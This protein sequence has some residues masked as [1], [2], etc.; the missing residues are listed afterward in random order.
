MNN[1]HLHC[2]KVESILSPVAPL[3][4]ERFLYISSGQKSMSAIHLS[5][6]TS[7][8]S[9]SLLPLSRPFSEKK[10][11]FKNFEQQNRF[12]KGTGGHS[13]SIC[14]LSLPIQCSDAD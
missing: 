2:Q 6:F 14:T 13:T 1:Y 3:H 12:L 8:F 9:E 7:K 4:Q 10:L 11:T 5:I